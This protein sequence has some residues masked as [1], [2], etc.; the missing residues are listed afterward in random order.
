MIP[1]FIFITFNFILSFISDIILNFL[2]RQTYSTII[3]KSLKYYFENQN[4]FLTAIFAGIT[5]TL[6]LIVTILLVKLLFG[7]YYPISLKHLF[8]F[9]I[10]ALPIGYLF[11]III[12]KFKIFGNLLDP[13][14]KV[15]GAGFWGAISFMFS[16]I[17]SFIGMKI[18]YVNKKQYQMQLH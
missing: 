16:I 1:I 10:I 11:D 9:L 18:K 4:P 15:A 13:Y 8:Y 7:F 17:L 14:Y 12:Y 6:A 2:S 3:I 5:V